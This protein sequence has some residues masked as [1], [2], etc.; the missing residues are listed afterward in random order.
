MIDFTTK[1]FTQP[2]FD[3]RLRFVFNKLAK[4][5]DVYWID[6]LSLKKVE[7][8]AG[9]ADS[10]ALTTGRVGGTLQGMTTPVTVT[11]VDLETGGAAYQT[12]AVTDGSG[13]FQF[14]DLPAGAY[15]LT[16]QAPLGY[17]APESIVFT[18][19]DALTDL[20]ISLEQT[21]TT[22]FLPQI[23]R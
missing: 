19:E 3:G 18:S 15:E 17:L 22:I 7:K 12:T 1:G 11:V 2:V 4:P 9:A 16:V 10:T 23:A 21:I 13:Q 8:G 20:E 5:G 6:N 14:T